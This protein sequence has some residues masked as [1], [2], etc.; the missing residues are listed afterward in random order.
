MST[1]S[2]TYQEVSAAIAA[3]LKRHPQFD[4]LFTQFE[5][6]AWVPSGQG[7][8]KRSPSGRMVMAADRDPSTGKV[9]ILFNA[10]VM[11]EDSQ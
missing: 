10:G 2:L 6:I 5:R 9:R 8:L 1:Y 3:I 7:M 4:Q 11:L